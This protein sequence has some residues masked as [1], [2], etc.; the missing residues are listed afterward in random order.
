MPVPPKVRASLATGKAKSMLAFFLYARRVADKPC[1]H[2]KKQS[3][4]LNPWR[5]PSCHGLGR[6]SLPLPHSARARQ[7]LLPRPLRL[8]ASPPVVWSA[9]PPPKPAPRSFLFVFAWSFVWGFL[10]FF[11]SILL[12]F[13][14][15]C[16]KIFICHIFT[17][18]APATP[19]I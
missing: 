14:L 10:I 13:L 6:W 8:T 15:H 4:N 19:K 18:A 17:S 9:P 11:L 12:A 2:S 5:L 16:S 1:L 7:F 3:Q